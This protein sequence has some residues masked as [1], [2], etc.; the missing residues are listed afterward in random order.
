MLLKDIEDTI[1]DLMLKNNL[2]TYYD[3]GASLTTKTVKL[4]ETLLSHNINIYAF[5]PNPLTFQEL[6][7][8]FG[9]AIQAYNVGIGNKHETRVLYSTTED[10]FLSSFSE[11]FLTIKTGLN[12]FHKA[13]CEI[14]RLDDFIN[15][16]VIYKP[17][18][19]KVDTEDWEDQVF[20]SIPLDLMPVILAEYHSYDVRIKVEDI[21]RGKYGQ[22]IF[23]NYGSRNIMRY[24]VYTSNKKEYKF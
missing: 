17:D 23:F 19:I 15:E 24:F 9:Y 20:C 7:D 2:K 18:L 22:N 4:F 10:L 8:K 13:A 5:E 16:E 12:N 14:V 3:I 21:L 6:K 1:V 11:K